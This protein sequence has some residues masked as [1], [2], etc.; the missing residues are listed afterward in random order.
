MHCLNYLKDL[1]KTK[2]R[3]PPVADDYEAG[4]QFSKKKNVAYCI[5]A[6]F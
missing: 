4:K 6:L 2:R 1:E 5:P 3:R